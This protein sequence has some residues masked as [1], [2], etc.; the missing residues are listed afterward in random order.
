MSL[1]GVL[2]FSL[3]S[4]VQ[5]GILSKFRVE[6]LRGVEDSSNH[7]CGLD[8]R[9]LVSSGLVKGDVLLIEGY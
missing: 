8:E 7:F 5:A 4:L 9:F 2:A 3:S 6:W 1:H